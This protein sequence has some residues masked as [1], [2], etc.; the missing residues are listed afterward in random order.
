MSTIWKILG[1]IGLL[2]VVAFAG[3][4]GKLIGRSTSERFFEGKESAEINSVLLKT[5]NEI[6]KKLP[7][8]IDKNTRLDSTVGL[9]NKFQYNYTMV[10]FTSLEIDQ[11]TLKGQFPLMIKNRACSSKDMKRF[12]E[13][14][15]TVD[16]VYRGK[17]GNSITTI[18]VTPSKCGY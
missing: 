8:M 10:S 3:S 14:G 11:S 18:S 9:N 12:F 13:N 16:Y 4:I 15:V 2:I 7:I 5:A 17:N 6:N 1:V